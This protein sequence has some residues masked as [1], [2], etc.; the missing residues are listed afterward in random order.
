MSHNDSEAPL[1]CRIVSLR[2]PQGLRE[3]RT[4]DRPVTI[5]G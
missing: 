2:L 5:S 3:A 4:R 1:T